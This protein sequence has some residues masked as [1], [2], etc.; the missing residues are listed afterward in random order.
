MLGDAF[1]FVDPVLSSGVLLAMH[2]A[3]V[4][5]DT[6][7]TCLDRPQRARRALKAYDASVRRG[8]RVF[9]WFIYRVTTPSLRHL[10]MNPNNRF[11][12]KEALL[13]VFAGDVFSVSGPLSVRVFAF[14][15]LYYFL[16]VC[17]LG[18]S[19]AAWKR[20]KQAIRDSDA[21]TAL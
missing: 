8:I 3:F 7:E 17:N 10:F 21:E 11:R 13:A 1:A 18:K 16:S 20:R 6:V 5:A 2:S 9:S 4:G 19:L 15:A 12:L 14:K